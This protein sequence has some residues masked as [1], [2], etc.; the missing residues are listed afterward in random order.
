MGMSA[1][2]FPIDVQLEAQASGARFELALY[3]LSALAFKA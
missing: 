1:Y 2:E 3:E